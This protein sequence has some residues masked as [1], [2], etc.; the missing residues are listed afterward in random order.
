MQGNYLKAKL[1]FDLNEPEDYKKHKCYC[2]AEEM[3]IALW[4][5]EQLFRQELKY[6]EDLNQDQYEIVSK[7]QSKFREILEERDIKFVLER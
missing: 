6:N 7:L 2:A 5:I 1:E 3:S 4:D